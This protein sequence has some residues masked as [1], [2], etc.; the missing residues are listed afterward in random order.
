MTLPSPEKARQRK[1]INVAL[2]IL[3]L[4]VL[5]TWLAL[6]P[7]GLDGKLHA[8]G[9]SVCHQIDSH[10]FTINGKVLPLCARCTGTF[11]G[12]MVSMAYLGIKNR[13]AGIPSRFKIVVL[14][15]F[16]VLF[17]ADGINSALTLLP[18]LR[19]IYPPS[20]YSRLASG[21]LFGIAL[22]NLVIPLWNQTLWREAD[23]KPVFQSWKQLGWLV[24]ICGAIFLLVI[25]NIPVLYYPI[26]ILSTLSVVTI[27]SMVYSLLWCI[28][29]K[30]ENSVHLFR[31][32]MRIF[33]A[34]SITAIL[35]IGVMDLIR[36]ILSGTW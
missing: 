20:N 5:T 22:A 28:I 23:P 34:G 2:I 19:P 12:V 8:V 11:L 1:W 30:K 32:G 31:D 35:Q 10:S 7:E 26:A 18:G 13:G 29:L 17:A 24:L 27:L 6:T 25:A 9:Y 33:I 36:Y 15:T 4:A 16:F 3:L 14:V 21:V